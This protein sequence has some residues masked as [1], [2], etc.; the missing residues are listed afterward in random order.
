MGGRARADAA[1]RPLVTF[2]FRAALSAALL[3]STPLVGIAA[4][5]HVQFDNPIFNGVPAPSYDAVTITYPALGT[6]TP[7]SVSTAAGRFQGTGSNVVGVS[8]SIFTDGLGDLYMYCY[9]VYESVGSGWN[10]DYTINF[11]GE[12]ARTLDFLGAVNAVLGGGDPYAWLHP[13]TGTMAAA[14]QLGIWESKYENPDNGWNLLGGSFSAQHMEA[15]T[16]AYLASFFSAMGNSPS[17]DGRYVMTL[18]AS[19]AQDMI[20]GDPPS[21]VPEPGMAALFGVALAGG[22]W[23]GR[24]RPTPARA[25]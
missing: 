19:G 9:D 25:A 12:T 24:R 22:L 14:I 21:S 11:D 20:T 10:V 2:S 8:P 4:T 13:T 15:S 18:E 16:Q 6:G 17:L 5:V 7:R 3:A 1:T 23:A